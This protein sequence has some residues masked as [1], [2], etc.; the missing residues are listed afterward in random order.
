M[1]RDCTGKSYIENLSL[2][3]TLGPPKTLIRGPVQENVYRLNLQTKKIKSFDRKQWINIMQQPTKF[4]ETQRTF[5]VCVKISKR[6]RRI[7]LLRSSEAV[8]CSLSLVSR[9]NQSCKAS[10]GMHQQPDST[11]VIISMLLVIMDIN[12][13]IYAVGRAGTSN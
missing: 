8:P 9:K 1:G 13:D 4:L 5:K 6:R 10:H 12:D 7:E 11:D 3:P 2:V